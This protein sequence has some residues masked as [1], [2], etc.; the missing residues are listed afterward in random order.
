MDYS[1]R[2][3]G[4]RLAATAA[5]LPFVAL[6]LLFGRYRGVRLVR[7][8]AYQAIGLAGALVALFIFGIAASAIG[9][10]LPGIGLLL[11]VLVGM[12]FAALFMGG[13]A[14]A[15]Y[16]AVMA[17]QGNYTHLPILTEW[18]WGRVNAGEEPPAEL[19]LG[20]EPRRRRR[21]RP[22]EGEPAAEERLPPGEPA[23]EPGSPFG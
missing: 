15:C 13:F 6:G 11:N 10:N 21:R 8:H 17:Y 20:G 3:E 1:P 4:V 5:Y 12:Y 14:V 9:G 18:V 2:A 22:G 7:F 19:D 16:A 23:E